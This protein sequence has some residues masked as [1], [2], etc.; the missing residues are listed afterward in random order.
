MKT[1]MSKRQPLKQSDKSESSTPIIFNS[2]PS[3]IQQPIVFIYHVLF[4]HSHFRYFLP[5]VLLAELLAG[6]AIIWK[7]PCKIDE[8]FDFIVQF[9]IQ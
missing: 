5:L 9:Q 4:S 7:V 2:L 1:A 3:F 8:T 6:I